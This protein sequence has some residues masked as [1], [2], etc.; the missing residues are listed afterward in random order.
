MRSSG[1]QLRLNGRGVTNA[2]HG[3]LDGR[4]F[5]SWQSEVLAPISVL[6]RAVAI[7]RADLTLTWPEAAVNLVRSGSAGGNVLGVSVLRPPCGH[8][9]A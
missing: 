6:S 5:R 1:L 7:A 8:P 9:S 4:T 3:R 2:T